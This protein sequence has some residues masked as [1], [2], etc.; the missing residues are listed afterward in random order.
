M[1][2][3]NKFL[4]ITREEKK[5]SE[6]NRSYCSSKSDFRSDANFHL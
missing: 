5:Y 1:I 6:A 4:D 3:L 2:V